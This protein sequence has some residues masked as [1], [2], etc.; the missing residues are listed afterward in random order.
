MKI[1]ILNSKINITDFDS[2]ECF[3]DNKIIL[4]KDKEYVVITGSNLVIT[5][6]VIDEILIS[7]NIK[8]IEFR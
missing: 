4:R 7:G 1:I 3:D 5:R 8:I 2:R 6:L